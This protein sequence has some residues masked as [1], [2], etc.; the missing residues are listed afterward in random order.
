[1]S[2]VKTDKFLVTVTKILQGL[3]SHELSVTLSVLEL[4]LIQ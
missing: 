2:F 4:F 1:M 3:V